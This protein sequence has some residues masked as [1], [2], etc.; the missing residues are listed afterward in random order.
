MSISLFLA[1][2]V[3]LVPKVSKAFFFLEF[4][5]LSTFTFF[6]SPFEE[7]LLSE[8]FSFLPKILEKI[9]PRGI[10]FGVSWSSKFSSALFI[11]ESISILEDIS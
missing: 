9:A 7:E 4:G 6:F 2:T 5:F 10:P 8:E 1:L 11:I 3:R